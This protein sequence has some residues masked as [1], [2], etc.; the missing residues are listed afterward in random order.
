M[1][2]DRLGLRCDVT[3]ALGPRGRAGRRVP[4]GHRVRRQRGL[5][6]GAVVA[7]RRALVVPSAFPDRRG[8]PGLAAPLDSSDA[9]ERAVISGWRFTMRR[10]ESRWVS[11]GGLPGL[12]LVMVTLSNPTP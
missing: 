1:D 3:T 6:R 5:G 10:F 12:I 4:A 8:H 7:C 9:S 11:T 2:V